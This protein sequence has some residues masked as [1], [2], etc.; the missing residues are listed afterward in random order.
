MSAMVYK[1]TFRTRSGSHIVAYFFRF[2]AM[3]L[4][5][6]RSFGMEIHSFEFCLYPLYDVP[7]A[8]HKLF[9]Q[10]VVGCKSPN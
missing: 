6:E 2:V 8:V 3:S 1:A 7:I 9:Y 5:W 4:A 10:L